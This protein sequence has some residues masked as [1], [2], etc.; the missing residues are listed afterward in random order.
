M[1]MAPKETLPRN[2]RVH[3]RGNRFTLGPTVPRGVIQIVDESSAS[4][5]SAS[6]IEN[7]GRLELAQWIASPH[8]PL[9]ARVMVNRIWQHH[10]GR[11]L[12]ETSDNFGVRGKRPSHPELLDW[13]AARFVESGWS[14]K[15]MHRLMLLSSTYQQSAISQQAGADPRW[16]SSF[17]RRRLSAEELRDAMLAVSG[18]LDRAPGTNE[19]AQYLLSKAED[20][21]AMIK[22]NRLAADDPIY[23]TFAKRSIYLP[24]VRNMLPDVLALFDTADP[25]GVTAVR[26]ETIVASQALFLLNSPFVREQ[27]KRFSLRLLDAEKM[28]DEQRIE[29]AHRLA[30]GRS[31][32]PSELAQAEAFLAA[33][34][35]AQAAQARPA[36]ERRLSAWQSYCQILLCENEF[37]YIE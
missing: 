29:A 8:N 24:V 25:N 18:D 15:A 28:S 20:I 14:M 35:A 2:L 1:V 5:S 7:S 17:A 33:Y 21:G 6:L 12:V 22:P 3:L 11:G 34:L 23:T 26:N 32:S 37:L 13:L 30:F 4:D 16:L 31:P 10:F 27:A 36:D 9:T 19:S